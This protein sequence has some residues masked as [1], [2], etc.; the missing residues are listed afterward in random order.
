M[1]YGEYERH[2]NHYDERLIDINE[3]IKIIVDVIVQRKN[4]IIRLRCK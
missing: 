3:G 2:T 1:I 4:E